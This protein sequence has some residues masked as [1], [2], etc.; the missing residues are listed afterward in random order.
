MIALVLQRLFGAAQTPHPVARVAA[1]STAL[2]GVDRVVL[3]QVIAV[4]TEGA[5]YGPD[6]ARGLAGELGG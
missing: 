4:L 1:Y 6:S 5:L 2:A 3:V